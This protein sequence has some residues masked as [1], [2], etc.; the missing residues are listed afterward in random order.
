M[1]L[2]L[3]KVEDKVLEGWLGKPKEMKQIAFERGFID[4]D[5]IKLYTKDGPKDEG[6]KT[7]N[8]SFSL[9]RILSGLT[10]FVEEEKLLQIMSK[11]IGTSLGMNVTVD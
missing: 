6:G 4:L 1:R 3:N 7:I 9:K 10:D 11:C 5:N 2:T 8:E